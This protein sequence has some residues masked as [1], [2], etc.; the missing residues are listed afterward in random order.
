M[1]TRCMPRVR[2]TCERNMVPN[3]PA[4]IRPT[5]TGWPAASR[6]R[7]FAWRFMTD[8]RGRRT[9]DRYQSLCRLSSVV[10]RLL[11]AHRAG[12]VG[13]GAAL[14]DRRLGLD[15]APDRTLLLGLDVQAGATRIAFR[16]AQRIGR[17]RAIGTAI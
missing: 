4:P 7:S 16:P 6:S 9:E 2:R 17:R 1:A 3:L 5:V 15:P 11:P 14:A 10:C 8:D 12:D 13:F